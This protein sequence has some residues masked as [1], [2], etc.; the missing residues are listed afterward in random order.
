M[1]HKLQN[2]GLSSIPETLKQFESKVEDWM[3]VLLASVPLEGL[4]PAYLKAV[5]LH[6]DGY[7]LKVTEV[8]SAWELVK[9][10]ATVD[11]RVLECRFCVLRRET[12]EEYGPCPFHDKSPVTHRLVEVGSNNINACGAPRTES[13]TFNAELVTCGACAPEPLTRQAG[14]K[15]PTHLLLSDQ[16]SVLC[17]DAAEGGDLLTPKWDSVTCKTCIA[18]KGFGE[19]PCR[20]C[21]YMFREGT[22]YA[23]EIEPPILFCSQ[24]HYEEWLAMC[25][26]VP[27]GETETPCG[28]KVGSAGGWKYSDA[29]EPVTC[30]PC[31]AEIQA[32][33]N[34]TGR[35]AT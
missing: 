33:R 29:I 14:N 11:A 4:P 13:G 2:L 5:Q 32:Y 9:A 24:R 6:G 12:P 16:T 21:D 22:G 20:F 27:A 8:T 15:P 25:H 18:M 19:G 3:E 1:L 7:F 28:L 35:W 34:G 23:L 10:E 26:W 31:R 30:G 17:G